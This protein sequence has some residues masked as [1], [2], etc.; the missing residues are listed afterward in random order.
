MKVELE[1]KDL[2]VEA[3]ENINKILKDE[4]YHTRDIKTMEDMRYMCFTK[5]HSI[6][7]GKA[8][9]RVYLYLQSVGIK[10]L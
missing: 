3:L 7:S 5:S 2:E 1:R 4:Y 8:I 9:V 6:Y 10:V